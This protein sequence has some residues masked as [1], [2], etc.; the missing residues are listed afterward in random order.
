M[1]S[2]KFSDIESNKILFE[3]TERVCLVTLENNTMT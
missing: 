1:E 2:M 3:L